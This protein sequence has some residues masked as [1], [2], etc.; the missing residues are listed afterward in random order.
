MLGYDWSFRLFRKEEVCAERKEPFCNHT[1]LV[2]ELINWVCE[3]KIPGDFTVDS[4]FTNAPILNPIHGK[5][6]PWDR[7]RGYVGDLKFNRQLVW[8]G[9]TLKASDL[10]ASIPPADSE[11]VAD[12]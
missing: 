8:K 11:G 9:R 4:Y 10:A 7:P 6:D 2:C 5:T 12:R 1:Q 3:R